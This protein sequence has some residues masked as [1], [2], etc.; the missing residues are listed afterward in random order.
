MSFIPIGHN[1]NRCSMHRHSF[2]AV[3]TVGGVM[4]VGAVAG[5]PMFHTA[6][7]DVA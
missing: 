4:I 7:I 1:G 3:Q 6:K 5:L 2:Y